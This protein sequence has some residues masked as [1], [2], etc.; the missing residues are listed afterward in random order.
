MGS[1][2]IKNVVFD[3]GNVIV[4]W[5]PLEIA[6]LTFGEANAS[7]QLTKSIFQSET[8]LNLNKGLI[9]ESDAEAHYRQQ[10]Q[11]SDVECERLFYYIKRT[12]ILLFGSV[13]LVK[14][15]KAAGYKVYALTDNVHEIVD[16]LKEEYTFWPLF[17]GAT[18]SAELGLLK[19]DAEIYRALLTTYNLEPSETVFIDDMPYNVE[20][21]QAVGITGIQFE[22]SAQCEQELSALGLRF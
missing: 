20:G 3:I 15:I 19:P 11:L 8:W 5:S 4:R 9:S 10:L 22:N 14:R 13:E 12:Q 21:A 17:D 18:V 7:E 2:G 6:R 16:Y 1:Q